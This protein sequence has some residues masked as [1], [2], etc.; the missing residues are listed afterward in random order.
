[1]KVAAPGKL[2]LTGAYA[3][4]ESAPAIVVAVDRCAIADGDRVENNP[5]AEV[6]AAFGAARAPVVDAS[7]LH[8]E[9][10]KLGLGSSAAV[11]VASMAL[12]AARTGADL[13]DGSVRRNL[14]ERGREAHAKV[15]SGG[16]GVDVAASV[17]GGVL[18]YELAGARANLAPIDLPDGLSIACFFSGTSARTSDL[19]ARVDALRARDA[20]AY[21]ARI[22][23][24]SLA[25]HAAVEACV[26]NRLPHF[27]NAARAFAA[28]LASLGA[29]ADA[30][31]VTP[32]FAKLAARAQADGAA[33]FPSG[34]G[35]GDVAVHLGAPPS[36]D[37]VAAASSLGMR[38]IP[39]AI[40]RDGVRAL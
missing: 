7:A 4:L 11:L 24:L 38:Y 31:I 10:A 26:A 2:L 29:A 6:R 34:A 22:G 15:Q 8:H 19:R 12:E 17:Y 3:V 40:D 14:F 16:S 25:S 33:F 1:V 9:G 37:F 35:G 30:P 27:M 39:F 18:R 32:A 13:R 36:P 28:A 20:G 21:R 23:E 5:S